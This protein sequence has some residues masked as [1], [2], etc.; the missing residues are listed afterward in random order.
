VLGQLLL[1]MF[2]KMISWQETQLA[3]SEREVKNKNE[4]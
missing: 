3:K 1:K 4:N 2:Q